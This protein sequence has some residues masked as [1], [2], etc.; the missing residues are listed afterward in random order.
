MSIYKNPG[1]HTLTVSSEL[2]QALT[3]VYVSNQDI[4]IG[5]TIEWMGIKRKLRKELRDGNVHAT[6]PRC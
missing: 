1:E 2:A 5:V 6:R 3:Y 4:G